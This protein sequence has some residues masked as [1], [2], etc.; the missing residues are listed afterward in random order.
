M[1]TKKERT[2]KEHR[3]RGIKFSQVK[4]S[5][6]LEKA[7]WKGWRARTRRKQRYRWDGG[8][9][10]NG[11]RR[12]RSG[13]LSFCR[14]CLSVEWC[15]IFLLFP[16]ISFSVAK[17]RR[18]IANGAPVSFGAA[19]QP[20]SV[21]LLFSFHSRPWNAPCSVVPYYSLR[22]SILFP[23][24]I[25]HSMKEILFFILSLFLFFRVFSFFSFLFF[26]SCFFF[27]F[28]RLIE[29]ERDVCF[30]R[31]ISTFIRQGPARF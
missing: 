11:T 1:F 24:F 26:S 8:E 4:A 27:F 23:P 13:L 17:E 5:K 6:W 9:T 3:Q 15:S 19:V 16:R 31:G 2:A 30:S 29:H 22:S 25:C 12:R 14:E 28:G 10:G 7:G 21:R 18:Q 20:R